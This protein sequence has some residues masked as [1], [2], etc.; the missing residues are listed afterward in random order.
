MIRALTELHLHFD[1]SFNILWAYKKLQSLK[2]IDETMT[3]EDFYHILFAENGVKTTANSFY[4]YKLICDCLQRE[5]DIIEAVDILVKELH[6]LGIIYAEIRL[7]PQQHTLCGLTQKEVVEAVCKGIKE[8]AIKYPDVLVKV[9]NCMMHKGDSALVNDLENRETI[10]V[11]KELMDNG[12]VVGLDLAG[13]ENNCP[14][15]EYSYLYELANQENI[16]CTIHAGEMGVGYNV[17]HALDMHIKRIG[18]GIGAIEYPEVLN[19]LIAEK[20]SL[21]I[22]F[23]SN[24]N[25]G[26]AHVDHPLRKLVDKGVKV[27]INSDNMTF[28]NTCASHEY[29]LLSRLGFT[30]SELVSFTFNAIDEAFCSEEEKTILKKKAKEIYHL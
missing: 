12:I 24:C 29:L 28:A 14:I 7:A 6:D 2:A 3:Y 27:S 16:P 17:N 15:T 18:H 26:I 8:A 30:D 20:V 4:K 23:T 10:K 11:T 5:E 21:E 1:G 22:C 9:I 19:R 25:H 13:Y